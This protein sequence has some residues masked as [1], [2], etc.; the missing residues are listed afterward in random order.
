PVLLVV[1]ASGMARTI[2]AIARGFVEFDRELPLR[3]LVANRV[4]S[5]G[6]LDLLRRTGVSPPLVG[7]LPVEARYAFPERHLGLRTADRRSVPDAILDPWGRLG[8]E[9]LDVPAILEMAR[10]VPP[11]AVG[12]NP[13]SRGPA[14][15][16]DRPRIGLAHDDAFHFYY[17]DN[18]ARLEAL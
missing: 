11:L 3:G 5:R 8:E 16:L 15:A 13:A 7:G 1:D 6:H 18:L 17:D 9:W 2:A 12:E 14:P 4:G 10:A